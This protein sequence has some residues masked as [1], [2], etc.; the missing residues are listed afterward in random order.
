MHKDTTVESFCKTALAKH[1]L[2]LKTHKVFLIHNGR[3]IIGERQLRDC[4]VRSSDTVLITSR[5]LIGG[6]TEP[7]IAAN[8]SLQV[9]DNCEETAARDYQ[10]P[11]LFV[12][13][14]ADVAVQ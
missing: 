8:N 13:T 3:D 5:T 14:D 2:P 9:H 1:S 7:L 11:S 4:G 10:R 12:L 6:S